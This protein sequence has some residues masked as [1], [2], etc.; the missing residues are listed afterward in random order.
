[1]FIIDV[2]QNNGIIDWKSVATNNPK[3]DG[4]FIKATEG[5][6]FIDK[7]LVYNAVD[8]KSVGLKIG[9]YHFASLNSKDILK[10]SEAEAYCFLKAIEKLPKNDLPLILD[11]ET[12]KIGLT[13]QEVLQWINNFFKCLK[14][15]NYAL[16]S[17]TPFLNYNLPKNH[18]LGNIPLWIAAY[19]PSLKLPNGWTKCYLWQYSSKGKINGIKGNVDL[20]K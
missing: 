20:N 3:V 7:Q 18:G 2:S 17:Y 12:N 4:V 10:D 15:T 8:A 19:T 9:Y 1:M 5:V 13:S 11:L 14:T 6:G 16:Y